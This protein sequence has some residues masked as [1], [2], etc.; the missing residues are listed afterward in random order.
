MNN[1]SKKDVTKILDSVFKG[2]RGDESRQ[3]DAAATKT[4]TCDSQDIPEPEVME[5]A[6]HRRFTIE[7]KAKIVRE[8]DACTELG[9][10]GALLRREGLY[11]SHLSKWRR[12]YQMGAL[13]GLRDDKR[14]RRRTKQPLEI[15]NEQLKKKN[16]Q[17]KKRLNKAEAIIDI[18]KKISSVL[19][20]AQV[21][22]ESEGSN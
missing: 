17:L 19:T 20:D 8:A 6:K 16:A 4:N 18:Q 10:I 7:Y 1:N 11:S 12:A 3:G 15:E 14:G 2:S 9:Q 13:A 22:A 21:S 5:K